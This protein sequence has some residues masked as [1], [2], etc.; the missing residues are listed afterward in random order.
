[1]TANLIAILGNTFMTKLMRAADLFEDFKAVGRITTITVEYKEGEDV[2]LERAGKLIEK[3]VEAI[4]QAG[5]IPIFVHLISIVGDDMIILNKK[6]KVPYYCHEKYRVISDGR[7]W[8]TLDE[9]MSK[10]EIK[11]GP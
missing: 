3:A 7:K 4:E 9:F 6:L 8:Y 5:E 10:L 1:M 11:K 2:T